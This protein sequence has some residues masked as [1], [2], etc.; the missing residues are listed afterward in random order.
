MNF[1]N[2]EES[3]YVFKEGSEPEETKQVLREDI[4]DD[5]DDDEANFRE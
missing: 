2:N 1:M 5:D 3:N 4:S